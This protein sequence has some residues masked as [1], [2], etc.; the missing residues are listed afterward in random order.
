METTTHNRVYPGMAETIHPIV[1]F[2]QSLH[3]IPYHK[4]INVMS[5]LK[6]QGWPTSRTAVLCWVDAIGYPRENYLNKFQQPVIKVNWWVLGHHNDCY[7]LRSH[8]IWLDKYAFIILR[9]CAVKQANAITL[10]LKF[11]NHI[12]FSRYWFQRGVSADWLS[13]I[14]VRS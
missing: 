8:F 4:I 6:S 9:W 11:A 14:A 10:Y 3:Q 5:Q 2:T 13:H 1:G 7:M 12:L